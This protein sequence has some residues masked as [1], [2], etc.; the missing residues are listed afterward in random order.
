MKGIHGSLTGRLQEGKDKTVEAVRVAAFMQSDVVANGLLA[1]NGNTKTVNFRLNGVA[2]TN[3]LGS[4]AIAT[5]AGGA[6]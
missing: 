5:V 2:G 3:V 6:G 1:A 4:G